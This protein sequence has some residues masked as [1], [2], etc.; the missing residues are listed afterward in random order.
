[1][2]NFKIYSNLP[3][4]IIFG[5]MISGC[6]TVAITGSTDVDKKA[7]GPH[8]KFAV[9]SIASMKTFQG[10]KGIESNVHE[11]GRYPWH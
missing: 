8:K 9:V 2:R 10:E 6:S 5:L 7:F 11:Y 1:M 3:L 4:I